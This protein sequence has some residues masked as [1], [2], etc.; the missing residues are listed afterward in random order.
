[1]PKTLD[2]K[3]TVNLPKTAFS[4]K[5]NLP[6]NEPRWLAKWEE[7]DLYGSMRRA[8]QNAPIFTLH[9][10]PPYANGRIHLGTALN[11]ILK[12]LIVKSKNMA[13]F[14]APYLPGWDCHGLPVEHNVDKELGPRKAQMSTVEVRQAC[15]RY[16]DKYL[17][18]QRQDFKRL[19]IFGEWEHPYSTMSPEYEAFTAEAFLKFLDH[20]YVY[21]GLKPVYWCIRDRTA[22]AEAEVEYENHRSPSIYVRYRMTSDPAEIDAALAGR[23]VYVMIWTTTPW[24]LP[25]SMAVAFHPDFEYVAVESSN[26]TEVYILEA[27]R[28]EPTLADTGL[29]TRGVLARFPGRKLER[30]E[31]QHPFL[32]RTVVGVLADYVT[33][34]D[35]TGAVHT[36]PGHGREDFETGMRYGIETFNPVGERGEFTE[37]L[38]EYRG[39]TVFEANEAIIEL[40]RARGALVGPPHALDHSYP[41]CWRCHQ[42]VIFRTSNQW[43]IRMDHS[44]LRQRTLEE[45]K[46]VQWSPEWGEGRISNMVAS[47]PDWCVSRQRAWGVPITVFYCEPCGHPLMDPKAAAP[48]IELF[49]KEGADAWFSH[50]VEDLIAPGTKCPS[51]GGTQFRKETDILDVWFDSGSSHYA[52]LGRRPDLP[53]PADVYIEGGD[54]HRG[55]FQSSLLIGMITH[56]AAPFHEVLTVGWTLDPQGRAMSKSLGNGID[57][58]DV[59]RTHGAEILRLWVAS[60]DFR[61]D[62]VLSEQI[63]QRLSEAYRKLR[64]TFRYC[65]GNLY[66]FDPARDVVPSDSLEE[67]DAWALQRTADILT[68][69]EAAYKDYAFHR[70][71]RTLYDFATVDLSAFYFDILKDRLYT[72]PAAS[73]RRRAAQWTLYHIADALARALAP[74]LTFTADEV[75]SHLPGN[76]GREWSVHC[77]SFFPAD[78]VRRNVPDQYAGRLSNWPRLIA[79]RDEVLKAL[80]A[81]RQEKLIGGGLEARILL[82]ADAATTRLLEQYRSFLPFLFIV[83]QVVLA[84]APDA[85]S[86]GASRDPAASPDAGS[87]TSVTVA[88]EKASGAKCARCWNY[89]EHVGEDTDYPEV[90]ERCSEALHEIEAGRE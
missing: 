26:G 7:G 81:A 53:W 73:A 64:N 47:R 42:P 15:R 20:G 63:L 28:L 30:T 11:K 39:K 25:A 13:G 79:I 40:V 68:E 43:F 62:V 66:D 3:S 4:M 85:P 21:R 17:N 24:T 61:E 70:V 38:P 56:G 57:P 34:E 83:S 51:C 2:L 74:I 77:S 10:G 69:V 54:Q 90:C 60:V 67:I 22:L 6:Q 1:M 59:I 29:E 44:E 36:A 50:P 84:S 35:G 80:E 76:S 33:A 45:V 9:D 12:D 88:V 41:H 23:T 78:E 5:A 37:G 46:K 86:D 72:A 27:R 31:F 87:A 14:N 75:W 82:R 49:R 52:V 58:N 32:D 71:Y 18:L 65:L 48:A 55:W 89:S 19:G 8:R 16:A